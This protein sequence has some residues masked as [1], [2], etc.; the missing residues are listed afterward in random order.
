M[1]IKIV[2]KISCFLLVLGLVDILPIR[3][4]LA[5]RNNSQSNESKKAVRQQR[6]VA[7]Q[8]PSKE[9]E[10]MFHQQLKGSAS[11]GCANLVGVT[12]N[13]LATSDHVGQTI[14]SHPTMT[15]YFPKVPGVPVSMALSNLDE[16]KLIWL[17]E[18]E[19][20][21]SGF[22]TLTLPKDLAGLE[23]G[24][25]Y[26]WSIALVCNRED[27]FKDIYAD[28]LIRRVASPELEAQLNV[29]GLSAFERLNILTGH[30]IWYDSLAEIL[31]TQNSLEF[32]LLKQLLSQGGWQEL[33]KN[34][35]AS[36]FYWKGV[37]EIRQ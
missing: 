27:R 26:R 16:E 29:D 30:G 20:N 8:P 25:L 7:F 32:S 12:Q 11:R 35:S 24:K 36:E 22:V 37:R 23:V 6:T 5:Q 10:K 2:A 1:G 34:I 15:V 21:Q 19:I 9:K 14:S 18:I 13:L 4:G 28:A 31:S 17:K 33:A 3:D